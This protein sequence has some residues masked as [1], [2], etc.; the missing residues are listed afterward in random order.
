MGVRRSQSKGKHDRRAQQK[1]DCNA[2]SQALACKAVRHLAS[3]L[4]FFVL[5]LRAVLPALPVYVCYEMGGE[6]VLGPCCSAESANPSDPPSVSAR[7][8]VPEDQPTVDAQR[9]PQPHAG[10]GLQ[11]PAL[12]AVVLA[13]AQPSLQPTLRLP[14]ARTG[15]PPLGPPPSLR[16]ILRI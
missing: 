2:T 15:P 7:C 5:V 9:P 10:H 3:I 16:K 6:H 4:L 1:V 8:C 14:L 13:F 11:L 12:V